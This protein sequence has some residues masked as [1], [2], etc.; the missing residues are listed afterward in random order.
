MRSSSTR[1]GSAS[2]EGIVG[3]YVESVLSGRLITCR[4]V[5]LA[6]QRY[7]NDLERGASRGLYFDKAR[8]ARA[9][10]F[11]SFLKHSKGE[12]AGTEF[13]LSPWQVFATWQLMGWYREDGRRR[14]RKAYNEFARKNGKSTW[15]GGMGLLLAFAD[16]EPGAEVYSAATKKDQAR[17]VHGE[18]T[19]MVR[20]SPAL[21]EYVQVYKDS[22]VRLEDNQK[23]EPLGA[24]ED[25]LDGLNP[26]A[27]II[28]EV[29]A[30][31]NRGVWDVLET[32]TGSRRNPMIFAITTAGTDQTSLC[33]DLHSYS[34]DLLNGT[35]EDDNFFAFIATLDLDP[36]LGE[37]DRW[38]DP[39]VWIKAN[40]NLGVSVKVAQLQEMATKAKR[41]PTFLNAFLRLHLN[42]WTKQVKRWIMPDLWDENAGAAIEDEALRG[43]ACYGGLDLSSVSDITAWILLFEDALDPDLLHIRCRFW[44][45]EE[46]LTDP[47]NKYHEQYQ[48][49]HR[50][51]C[52]IATPGNAIDYQFVRAQIVEDAELF[53]LREV[54]VDRLFQGYQLSME[55]EDDGLTVLG[56]GMGFLSMAAP[57]KEF[58]RRLLKKKLHHGN[59]PVLR[60]M[61]GNV[62]VREDPAGNLKPDKASS[63][64]KID[65]IVG[66]LLALDR[67][68]R[69]DNAPSVYETRGF[70]SIGGNKK[71]EDKQ[72]GATTR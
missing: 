45:P 52:I 20:A 17:I 25:T 26:H 21:L 43:R 1:R 48:A 42:V 54:C 62:A 41:L 71:E 24:D 50:A 63:Q 3:D 68:M 69:H 51:G 53:E 10:K 66:I 70:L 12:W 61:A 57:M 33:W 19:R 55:L 58:E 34:M 22:L 47:Q 37:V 44:C 7:L 56:M 27:A 67:I 2:A 9:V 35:I 39:E 38:D 15:A 72:D 64:G 5:K 14:F 59:H 46:R 23:Y 65:G 11:F 31:K 30:H 49:W 4:L 8:A 6:V 28:D 18:S 29:H 60:W 40:P 16:E 13:R 32:A 36:A